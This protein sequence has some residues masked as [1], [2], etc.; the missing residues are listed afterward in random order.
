MFVPGCCHVACITAPSTLQVSRSNRKCHLLAQDMSGGKPV[1]KSLVDEFTRERDQ[2]L[3]SDMREHARPC[4]CRALGGGFNSTRYRAKGFQTAQHSPKQQGHT[5]SPTHSSR[6]P[7]HGKQ[8]ISPM[9]RPS[10]VASYQRGSQSLSLSQGGRGGPSMV[11]LHETLLIHNISSDRQHHIAPPLQCD[12]QS[13]L[14][15][16]STEPPTAALGLYSPEMPPSAHLRPTSASCWPPG[17]CRPPSI[18]VQESGTASQSIPARPR[19][20]VYPRSITQAQSQGNTGRRPGTAHVTL[21][22]KPSSHGS[23]S[24][25]IGMPVSSQLDLQ[26]SCH[27]SQEIDESKPHPSAEI[28]PGS[29]ATSTRVPIR[30]YAYSA[31]LQR[32][33]VTPGGVTRRQVSAVNSAAICKDAG[34]HKDFRQSYTLNFGLGMVPRGHQ[35][36]KDSESYIRRVLQECGSL[37]PLQLCEA[38]PTKGHLCY[39]HA[40]CILPVL[41][42][43]LESCVK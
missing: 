10:Q 35:D 25:N 21:P 13:A 32:Q 11:G 15:C 8:Q 38:I 5:S 41:L 24:Q 17:S 16:A 19:S 30:R 29:H 12:P 42:F 14:P 22:S 6:A 2:V 23:L 20:A 33:Q 28:W 31:P 34:E 3:L 4:H 18:A 40:G 26:N 37:I 7:A 1:P 39:M 36:C 43:T 27:S 9:R